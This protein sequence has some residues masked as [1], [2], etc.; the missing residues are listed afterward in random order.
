MIPMYV[1]EAI[2]FWFRTSPQT[3]V[4]IDDLEGLSFISNVRILYGVFLSIASFFATF[5]KKLYLGVQC[6]LL[7]PSQR[8]DREIAL[9]IN[10][11]LYNRC[12]SG[13]RP[14]SEECYVKT[15]PCAPIG[16][17]LPPNLRIIWA[18][19][20]RP[21]LSCPLAA[22]MMH[23]YFWPFFDEIHRIR[24]SCYDGFGIEHTAPKME[25]L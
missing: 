5:F 18:C 17:S 15:R 7:C 21:A 3:R 20:L 10:F 19:L 24:Q 2:N 22:F 13:G 4:R 16:C 23:H 6:L 25:S 9:Y 12:F 1:K 14:G 11:T 8:C